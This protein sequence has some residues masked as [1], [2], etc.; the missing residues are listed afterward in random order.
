[1]EPCFKVTKCQNIPIQLIC[2]FSQINKT[3]GL[4][5]K[6]LLGGAPRTFHQHFQL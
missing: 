2:P 3:F 6:G 5:P 1:M 4:L